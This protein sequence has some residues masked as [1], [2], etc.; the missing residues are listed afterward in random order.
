MGIIKVI[1]ASFKDIF[2]IAGRNAFQLA[3]AKAFTV[4][5]KQ[6]VIQLDLVGSDYGTGSVV[7]Y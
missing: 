3:A 7:A 6:N 2:D 1:S 4:P 5:R